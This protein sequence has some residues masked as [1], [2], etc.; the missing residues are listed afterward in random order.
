MLGP[1]GGCPMVGV[2]RGSKE[3]HVSDELRSG[4]T[5]F[6]RTVLQ[7]EVITA[8][9]LLSEGNS[10]IQDDPTICLRANSISKAGWLHL[11]F[12]RKG[13]LLAFDDMRS[14]R[15]S[16]LRRRCARF[17]RLLVHQRSRLRDICRLLHRIVT[18]WQGERHVGRLFDSQC[19]R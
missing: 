14:R 8:L 11:Q 7:I 6:V 5:L 17:L 16:N 18:H 3:S 9:W 19:R 13:N 2:K 15:M 10:E 1:G 4:A 12:G